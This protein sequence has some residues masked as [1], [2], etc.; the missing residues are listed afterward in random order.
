MMQPAEIL[1]ELRRVLSPAD[2]PYV[3]AALSEDALVWNSLQQPEF[4]H[5][6]LSDESVIP[7]SWSPASLA[8][9]PLGN[10]VSFADLTAEHIPGIEVSLRKQ[11]LEVLENTLHNSQPPA[12]LAQAGLLAL[13]LRE[14]RRKTQ[15]WRG[16][17]NELLSVQN[18]ST[19]SLV[20]LWQTPLACLY[21]MIS[22]KWDFLESLL[23]QDS[24]HPAIDWISHIILSNPLDLQTQVQMIHDLMSQLVVEYQVEWLRYLTGKGRFALASGI[25]DQLLVTGRDFFAALEEPFQPDHAEWVTA[26][27]KV[28]DNQLAATLYQIA[29]RPLQA[30]IYLDK[31]R[32]LLQHWL[33]GSTLQM[34]TVIDREGK[35]NDAVYQECADLMAQM[36]VSTQLMNEALFVGGDGI[37]STRLAGL[38][39]NQGTIAA[40]IGKGASKSAAGD[41]R[42]GQNDARKAVNTW[43]DEVDQNPF[44]LKGQYV[45]DWDPSAL[46]ATLT[47]QGLHAEAIEAAERFLAVRPEDVRLL[48][49]LSEASHG[50]GNDEKSVNY[51]L[52][53]IL[54]QP[55]QPEHLRKLAEVWEDR[56][57]WEAALEERRKV[58]QMTQ[59]PAVDDKLT[60]AATA[61]GAQEFAEANST[62]ESILADNPDHGMAFTLMGKAAL[63]QGDLETAIAHLSKATMLIPE[64][65]MPWFELAEAYRRKGDTQQ[66]LE[67]LREAVLTAPDSADLHYALGQ[68]YL[69][70]NQMSD[71][72]PF[73]RQSARLAPE[74][75]QIALALAEALIT[76]GYKQEA[77]DVVVKARGRWRVHAELA[78]LHAKLL[79]KEGIIEEGLSI[80]EIALQSENPKAEWYVLYAESLM[81]DPEAYLADEQ[82]VVDL[83]KMAQAFNAL[84]QAVALQPQYFEARLLA[85]EVSLLR[86]ENEPAFGAYSQLIELREAVQEEW[87]WR[88]QAGLGRSALN[89]GQVETALASLQ[90]AVTA[91]PESLGLNRLLADAFAE[92]NLAEA[93]AAAA[94]Q[95][96]ALAPDDIN[97]LTWYANLMLRIQ[98][99]DKAIQAL[100]AAVEVQPETVDLRLSLAEVLLANGNLEGSREE[101]SKVVEEPSVTVAQLRKAANTFLQMNDNASA[102]STL[103]KAATVNGEPDATLLFE[104]AV[105]NKDIHKYDQAL[106]LTQRA[107]RAN[108]NEAAYHTFQSDLLDQLNRS[109]AAITSLQQA[110]QL[111]EAANMA[112]SPT[113]AKTSTGLSTFAIAAT[114]V[115]IHQRFTHLLQKV[116]NLG[117]AFVHAEK[118]IELDPGNAEYRF[119]GAEL[120]A[121]LLQNDRALA[122]ATIE[123]NTNEF[124]ETNPWLSGLFSLQAE[125]ALEQGDVHLAYRKINKGLKFNPDETRLLAARVRVMARTGDFAEAEE[126]YAD[127]WR[128][129]SPGLKSKSIRSDRDQ[130]QPQTPES[131][132]LGL[133]EAAAELYRWADV[134]QLLDAVLRRQP[135]QPLA[136][137]R[138][139]RAM[140][141]AAEWKLTG[142]ALGCEAHL[143]DETVIS[144]KTYTRFSQLITELSKMNNA[145]EI[146]RWKVRGEAVFQPSPASVRGFAALS[147]TGDDAAALVLALNRTGNGEGACQV[148][149]QF[150]DHAQVCVQLATVD[151]ENRLDYNQQAALRAV[152]LEPKN[153]VC[154]IALA[155]SSEKS[156]DI[157]RALEAVETALIYWPNEA[158]WQH[159]AATLAQQIH[160]PEAAR[161][162]LEKTLELMPA[163]LDIALELGAVYQT[164]KDA[165]KAVG[166]LAKAVQIAP[167]HALAWLN[168]GRALF[169]NKQY[170]DALKAAAQAAQHSGEESYKGLVL[171]GEILLAAGD[172]RKAMDFAREAEKMAPMVSEPRLLVS[173]VLAARGKDKEALA[174]LD[175]AVEEMPGMLALESERARFI[176]RLQGAEAAVQVLQ[177]LAER[178]PDNDQVISTYAAALAESGRAA[179]AEKAALLALRLDPQSAEIH[180]LLGRLFADSGQ[181][182]KS[183]HHLTESARLAPNQSDAYLDLGRVFTNQRDFSQ[184]LAAY[185]QA[186]RTAPEDYRS[187]YQAGLIL[188]DGKDYL[189]AETM[190]RRAADLAPTDVNIRRQLGAIVALNLV[191]NCQEANSCL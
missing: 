80:L 112:G 75:V 111:S 18:K 38:P 42:E 8:L 179:E 150:N 176:Y 91:K 132:L 98:Q 88:M 90:N 21:G 70:I 14:R 6:V 138:Q 69:D 134:S 36:P 22:D 145:T 92:G 20:E 23:P 107:I 146:E 161:K 74:S 162:H 99:L 116:D 167:T 96:L 166:V 143:P 188:R 89:L 175:K 103:E 119:V 83:N 39:N 122:L 7:T 44:V 139:S 79:L 144:Q 17:L 165:P 164:L 105:L 46:L 67:T 156:G 184:A 32:R 82:L 45:L 170:A 5:S 84:Q 186:M 149:D 81:G 182:D 95:T 51:R 152:A 11:A 191:H 151:L 169:A 174:T 37:I 61:I 178:Y 24:M 125:H 50:L 13:A 124:T 108:P 87:Y 148:G 68:A 41:D 154:H 189:A 58:V 115:D 168:Y 133:A 28:L 93:A 173:K 187:F 55:D 16:F 101:L 56:E 19:S 100:K 97:N 72:L 120:A 3:L 158:G 163:N 190:L 136:L 9:R 110:L 34:A 131:T 35:M 180:L 85:A 60:L 53:A 30:G 181:L 94:E 52:R 135:A 78:Y 29:G 26:S 73:L 48:G 4:L 59:T 114:P 49:W 117:E 77:L 40:R 159:W 66:M 86:G 157:G 57:D 155:K 121:K 153:P 71:A 147:M 33:V 12:N 31:T 106:D 118:T 47:S 129:V 126:L 123:A 141:R 63:A 54:L 27:R 15:S 172:D 113:A 171:S 25:A 137:L 140:V 65:Y 1:V 104:L 43:L 76:L 10:R 128:R 2:A 62:C 183:V 160:E 130:L 127:L 64:E 102:L 177:P 142:S 185:Q 109:Q